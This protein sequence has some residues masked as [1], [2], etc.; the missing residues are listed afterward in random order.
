MTDKNMSYIRILRPLLILSVTAVLFFALGKV[1][2]EEKF[3]RG[4]ITSITP[5]NFSGNVNVA[6][7]SFDGYRVN[8]HIDSEDIDV[9]SVVDDI[10][11]KGT[12]GEKVDIKVIKKWFQLKIK[13][14]IIT[15]HRKARD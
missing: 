14:Q 5:I 11:F 10:T 7:V 1:G 3:I 4:T 13:Y 8:V 12:V 15:N 2:Y 9:N 6:P